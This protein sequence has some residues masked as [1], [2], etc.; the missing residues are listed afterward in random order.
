[1][2]M[3]SKTLSNSLRVRVTR[4]ELSHDV[5]G[6]H[7]DFTLCRAIDR[8]DILVRTLNHRSGHESS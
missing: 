3:R 6:R 5:E 8:T 4:P 1:M 2:L 7:R